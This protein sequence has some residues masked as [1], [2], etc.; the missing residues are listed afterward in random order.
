MLTALKKPHFSLKWTDL[1]GA[2]IVCIAISLSSAAIATG[3][4]PVGGAANAQLLL[5]ATIFRFNLAILGLLVIVLPRLPLW[6]TSRAVPETAANSRRRIILLC[7]AALLAVAALLR[8]YDLNDGLWLDEILT[9]VLFVRQPLGTILSRFESENQHFLYSIL[10]Y[11]SYQLFGA[12][13][14]A[15]RL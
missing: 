13:A 9:D 7:L 11:L 6:D 1:C 15:L 12:N 2:L 14:W 10:G 3:L 8:L 4:D 5:G